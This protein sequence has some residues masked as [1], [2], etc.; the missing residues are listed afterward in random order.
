MTPPATMTAEAPAR[1]HAATPAAAP[2]PVVARCLDETCAA[3]RHAGAA[4]EH[5]LA[6]ALRMVEESFRE[7]QPRDL[8]DA[9]ARVQGS[10]EEHMEP[11]IARLSAAVTST[12]SPAPPLIP[13]AGKLIAP[14]AFYESFQQMLTLGRLL[15]APVIFAEDT[16]TIGT[17][18]VNPVAAQLLAAEI[19]T[20]VHRRF[21]IKPFLTV[22]LLDYPSWSFL[23]RKHFGL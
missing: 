23:I 6:A 17:G 19:H 3:L 5:E 21:G 7:D 14:S 4:N 15:N 10:D 8:L 16:D 18:S 12:L 11:N 1:R 20:A 13:F 2:D 22:A 9:L